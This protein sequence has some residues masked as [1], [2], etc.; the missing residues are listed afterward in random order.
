MGGVKVKHFCLNHLLL[1]KLNTPLRT[2]RFVFD[3]C[4]SFLCA[5]STDVLQSCFY[6]LFMSF[7]LRV[8]GC[9]DK[10]VSRFLAFGTLRL[11]SGESPAQNVLMSAKL[12]LFA[13]VLQNNLLSHTF[14]GLF[15][16]LKYL[17][18][19]AIC[20]RSWCLSR[21]HQSNGI[22]PLTLESAPNPTCERLLFGIS[23]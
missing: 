2:K 12:S 13:H 1:R 20:I 15:Y 6:F 17:H 8:Y 5:V 7:V 14:F 4:F 21:R 3:Y 19:C 11:K 16:R 22:H 23:F 18:Q 10:T 9:C